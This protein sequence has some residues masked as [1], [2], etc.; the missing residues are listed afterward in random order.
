MNSTSASPHKAAPSDLIFLTAADSRRLEAAEEYGA[1]RYAQAV[2]AEGQDSPPAWEE[3]R[4]GHLVFVAKGA[5]V[6]RAHGLGF[7]E[8]I[9]PEDIEHVERFYFERESEAQVDV[10]PY[11]DASLFESL[12][13]RGFQVAEFNQTLARWVRPGD[14]F[15]SLATGVEI[16]GIRAS[17]ARAWSSMLAQ[18]FFPPEMVAPFED[19]FLPWAKPEHPLSMAAFI[20][21]RM[22]AGAGGLIVPEH[23]VAGLFGAATLP[24]Y[25]G[26]GIQQAFMVER[27]RLAQQAGCDLGCNPHHAR[28]D[29][30]A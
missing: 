18:I 3:F 26:H 24:E 20:D 16:R 23:R 4:G 28:D 13:L 29:F 8:K 10:S 5:P 12:N 30:P 14:R 15:A 25:R 17:E 2:K 9:T 6:G 22:V 1:L 11:A 7:A 19:F 27:L 21:G